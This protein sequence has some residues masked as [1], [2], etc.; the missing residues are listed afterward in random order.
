MRDTVPRSSP[1]S[2]IRV[3][4]ACRRSWKRWWG[5]PSRVRWRWR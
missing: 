5:S 4:K 1:D 3:A 2:I